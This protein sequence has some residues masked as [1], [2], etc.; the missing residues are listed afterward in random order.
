MPRTECY[1]AA[2]ATFLVATPVILGIM[3][4]AR[5]N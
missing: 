5:N 2:I 4:F 1:T 3:T